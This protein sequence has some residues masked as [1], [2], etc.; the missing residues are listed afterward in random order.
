MSDV[1]DDRRTAQFRC[2]VAFCAPDADPLVREGEMRGRVIREMRGEGGFG[3][4]PVF[5]P[6]G[7]DATTAEMDADLKDE[8]SHRGK[9]LR[10]IAPVV[11]EALSH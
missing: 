4:D 1:P 9:A 8:L 7:Y 6:D 3:Y 11:A 2:A 5:V 10:A